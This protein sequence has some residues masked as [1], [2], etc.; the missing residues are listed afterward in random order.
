VTPAATT[1]TGSQTIV[2]PVRQTEWIQVGQVKPINYY[3]S[4][5]E[6]NG[7]QPYVQLAKEL[8]K[9]PDL[10]N[11]T[12]VAKITYLALNATNPEVKEAFE[13]MIKGGTP[14]PGD[15][16]YPVP[17]YNTEL[18]VLYWLA[19][20]NEL[21]KDDTLALAMAM[22]NG[23]WATMG[24]DQ[25]R[26]VAMHDATDMLVFLRETSEWQKGK[27]ATELESYPLEGKICLAWR[28]NYAA[29]SGRPH[30]LPSFKT[31]KISRW[32]YEWITVNR[33]SLLKM[34]NEIVQRGW[35]STD[36]NTLIANLEYF[37][38][39]NRGGKAGGSTHWVYK[40]GDETA[41]VDNRT[42][43]NHD[44]SNADFVFKFFLEN[45]YAFGDCGDETA[46]V[47]ALAKSVGV[48]TN[49]VSYGVWYDNRM[50]RHVWVSYY[51]PASRNWRSYERQAS[52]KAYPSY[53][54][55][56]GYL[57]VRFFVN[58]PPVIEPQYLSDTNYAEPAVYV[59]RTVFRT[60]EYTI[61]ELC[62]L[63]LRGVATTQMKQWLLYS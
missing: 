17:D 6:A 58:K 35:Y 57:K 46:L 47:D 14:Y 43:V 42:V 7:T 39:F 44:M 34:R 15:F 20:Q 55:D 52:M 37:F 32:A 61:E 9:L 22:S 25:V 23:L 38:Y 29:M 63:L 5:L 48:A 27:G 2:V 30:H 50:T 21:K 13:L 36:T 59:G 60:D 10:T 56:K 8:R 33:D 16:K 26:E 28:A 53:L 11:A 40:G 24:D 3:L 62:A 41:V 19:C 18:Q 12:A 1:V 54:D 51:D 45:G 49:P 4:L 31:S